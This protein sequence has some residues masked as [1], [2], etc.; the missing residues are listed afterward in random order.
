MGVVNW[1]DLTKLE[2]QSFTP[3]GFQLRV[4]TKKIN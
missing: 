1:I 4:V 2:N 3:N